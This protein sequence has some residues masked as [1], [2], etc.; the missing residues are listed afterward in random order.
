MGEALALLSLVL[1]SSNAL[2]VSVAA[3]RLGQNVGFLLALG[4]N[5]LFSGLLVLGQLVVLGRGLDVQWVPLLMFAIGG[6]FTSYLGRRL[7]FLSVQSIGPSRATSLQITNPVFAGIISWA[8]LGEVLGAS[9]IA[10]IAA[11][12]VGLYLTTRVPV[13]RKV[14]I[15]V[16]AGPGTELPDTARDPSSGGFVGLPTREVAFALIGAFSYA[17]GN[18]VRS[19]G[20]REWNEPVLGGFVG[21]VAGTLAY[22]LLHTKVRSLV[23]AVRKADRTGV[24][25]WSLSGVLTISAQVSLMAATRHIPIAVGVVVAAA[26]PVIVIPV[27]VILMKNTEAVTG[28]TVAGGLLILAG[29][30][31]LLLG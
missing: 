4:T 6:L 22:L 21:A 27:S 31:G 30:A 19:S 28:R 11:V 14:P 3:R 24:W 8:F 23:D 7:F 1:F 16:G 25:L 18:V 15:G 29:V 2:L 20:V 13:A 10:F 17:V 26:L 12:V 9:S 5:V